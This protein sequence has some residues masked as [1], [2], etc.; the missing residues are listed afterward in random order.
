M[1]NNDKHFSI[2][3][4]IKKKKIVATLKHVLWS[5]QNLIAASDSYE[6]LGFFIHYEFY[7]VYIFSMANIL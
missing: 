1:T 7:V 4:E 2:L 3:P 5:T 6:L